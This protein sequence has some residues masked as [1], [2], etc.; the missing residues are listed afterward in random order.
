MALF[1]LFAKNYIE[2]RLHIAFVS[3]KEFKELHIHNMR[4]FVNSLGRDSSTVAIIFRH[5]VI[6]AVQTIHDFYSS[7]QGR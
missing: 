2:C 5:F 1:F 3:C 7:W 4:T 6:T